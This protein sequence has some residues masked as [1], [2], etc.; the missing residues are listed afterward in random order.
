LGS[1]EPKPLLPIL[2]RPLI[3]AQ[4]E[5]LRTLGV[6]DIAIV[7]GHLGHRIVEALGDG[8]RYGV[9]L[10]Y[11]EQRERLGT[12]HALLCLEAFAERPFVLVLGDVYLETRDLAQADALFGQGGLA[13]LI[14]VRQEQDEEG[15]RANFSVE[16]DESGRVR[17]LVEKPRR[18]TTLLK[19]CGLYWLD[20]VVFESA[21]RTPRSALRDEY[22]ITDALQILLDSGARVEAA[23][24]VEH[25]VNLSVPRDLLAANLSALARTG[26]ATFV[27][28]HARVD[29]SA[30]LEH[31]VVLSEARVPG[32]ADLER[33]LVLSGEAVP[34]GRFRDSI[35]HAG[36][37]IQC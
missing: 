7:I 8:Q 10:S 16:L 24:V 26:R 15:V 21:R 18:P 17:R 31:A 5:M 30:R 29:G 14:A 6:H 32:G 2:D 13:A 1:A 4:I 35:F 9:R 27:A 25:D 11:L 28:E 22:E 37:E 3:V 34:R 19:G 33:C 20:P 12:A 36:G 23:A